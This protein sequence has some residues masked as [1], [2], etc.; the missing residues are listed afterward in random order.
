MRLLRVNDELTLDDFQPGDLAGPLRSPRRDVHGRDTRRPTRRTRAPRSSARSTSSS[1]AGASYTGVAHLD[2]GGQPTATLFTNDTKP[3]AAGQVG[4][5][6]GPRRRGARGRRPRRRDRRRDGAGEP[7]T[8]GRAR[9]AGRHDLGDRRR[10]GRRGYRARARPTSRSPRASTPIAY[11]VGP[12]LEGRRQPRPRR[13]RRSR[14]CIRRRRASRFFLRA[15]RPTRRAAPRRASPLRP[16]RRCSACCSSRPPSCWRARGASSTRPTPSGA[17]GRLD[18]A[19][20]RRSRAPRPGR[21]FR[22][23]QDPPGGGARNRGRGR[24]RMLPAVR[25][26]GSAK[27]TADRGPTPSPPRPPTGAG[28]AEPAGTPGPARDAPVLVR[29]SPG[30]PPPP[31]AAGT[32]T[33]HRGSSRDRPAG[34]EPAGVEPEGR[35]G[36]TGLRRRRRVVPVRTGPGEPHRDDPGRGPR[37]RP[38]RG[39][40]VRAAPREQDGRER[41]RRRHDKHA[42]TPTQ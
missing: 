27:R 42:G 38:G 16:V 24:R 34:R 2:A 5:T 3:T 28:R 21:V 19:H 7:G 8:G 12:P 40:A 10:R 11:T 31:P 29:P 36:R 32:R 17:T 13:P 18:A 1:R 15:S 30:R 4:L 41:R 37:G 35:M 20:H 22:P 6:V 9:T 39:R 23:P 26:D 33:G 14:A 25:P